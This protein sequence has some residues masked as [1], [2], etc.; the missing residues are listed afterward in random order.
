MRLLILLLVITI[1][2]FSTRALAEEVYITER[3]AVI[4]ATTEDI[5]AVY[6]YGKENDIESYKEIVLS[7]RCAILDEP[8]KLQK[9]MTLGVY[10]G[11]GEPGKDINPGSDEVK[12]ML[13]GQLKPVK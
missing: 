8:V 6:R 7:G 13:D 11:V 12:W 5:M 1:G 10:A 2:S 9:V 4:C 3:G